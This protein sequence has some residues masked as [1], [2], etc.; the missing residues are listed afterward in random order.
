[1]PCQNGLKKVIAIN[2]KRAWL[3]ILTLSSLINQL[4]IH[5]VRPATTYKIDALGG[6]A[7]LVGAITATYA[8]IPL[9]VAMPLGRLTQRRTTLSGLMAVGLLIM[10][11]GGALIALFSSIWLL[12]TGTALLGFGQLIFTIGGQSAVS[13]LAGPESIDSAF[14]WF[15]AGVSTGQMLGPLLAGWIISLLH[16]DGINMQVA[17]DVAIWCGAAIP[18]PACLVLLGI[19]LTSPQK[20]AVSESKLDNAPPGNNGAAS[21]LRILALP[22][23]ASH[24]VA[25][26]A[27]LA[28]T[29]ILVAFVPLLGQE[30]GLSPQ[31]VGILLAI[32]GIGS[33][34]S[35]LLL[36]YLSA[37]FPREVLLVISLFASA[38]CFVALP[39][40]MQPIWFAASLTFMGGFFLGLGQPLTM[41]MVSLSVPES[42][43]SPG[44][45][46]RLVGN[47]V[48]QVIVPA[49]AGALAAPAGATG[50]IL[51]SGALV[52]ASAADQTYRLKRR[53]HRP[54]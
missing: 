37:H 36:G 13:R 29:D 53:R 26:A 51:L 43:Q 34:A 39:M 15:T 4:T 30:Y 50:A 45:A 16:E 25:S 3:A 5:M 23:V 42:W 21:V 48:G 6:G 19:F 9:F 31:T 44:L 47:R 46:L 28:L 22:S 20:R 17:I 12:I 40:L 33:L 10:V 27:L 2:S 8:V 18:I 1:M 49:M 32:R 35:R 14:G 41:S 54:R 24:I 52:F 7:E 11:V 38:M